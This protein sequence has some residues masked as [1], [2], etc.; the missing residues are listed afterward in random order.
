MPNT[1]RF[2]V[3]TRCE[4]CEEEFVYCTGE[5]VDIWD[6]D[7]E[8]NSFSVEMIYCPHCKSMTKV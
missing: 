6:E 4:W 1:K 5:E 2:E 7:Y 8:G 3:K